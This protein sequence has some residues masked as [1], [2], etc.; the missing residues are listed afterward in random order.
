MTEGRGP[1]L[2]VILKDSQG[3]IV[4][5]L[6]GEEFLRLRQGSSTEPRMRGKILDQK[7]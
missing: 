7:F 4:R 1:G 5:Q 6:S 2:K 3:G